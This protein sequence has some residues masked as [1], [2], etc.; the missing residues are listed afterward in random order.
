LR[1]TIGGF[2]Y[3]YYYSVRIES[4]LCDRS[5]RYAKAR[6]VKNG[7]AIFSRSEIRNG[8]KT[9]RCRPPAASSAF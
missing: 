8:R 5:G 4:P 3:Y 2:P 6:L 7:I 1:N 9:F